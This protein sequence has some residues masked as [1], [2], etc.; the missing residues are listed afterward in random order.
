M[1]FG[2]EHLAAALHDELPALIA[3]GNHAVRLPPRWVAQSP[4]CHR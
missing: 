2:D 3:L 1:A 4:D